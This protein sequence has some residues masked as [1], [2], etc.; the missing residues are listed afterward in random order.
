MT[1]Q[2]LLERERPESCLSDLVLDRWQASEL[3]HRPEGD[4]VRS[5]LSG[6]S[7]CAGRLRALEREPDILPASKVRSAPPV[8]SEILPSDVPPRKRSQR[9][10]AGLT[11][12]AALAAAGLVLVVTG[13]LSKSLEPTLRAKG[14]LQL[15]LVVRRT[16]GRTETVLPAD[17]LAA[18]DSVRFLVSSAEPG[19]AFVIGLDAAGAVSAY[20][21]PV[22][23]PSPLPAGR[24]QALP[25]SVILDETLGA[26]RFL[27]LYC[28]EATHIDVVLAAGRRA[29]ASA[30]GDP[31]RVERIDLPCL[32]SSMTVEKVRRP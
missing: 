1:I 12:L 3:A 2:H 21:P 29:L 23:V 16:D 27:L 14:E 31:R 30:G 9:V 20:F 25:G 26:E 7:S 10:V 32:Q 17:S 15:E 8:G 24:S 19:F 18:G 4:A 28:N 13:S 6:C 11:G 5:H 22:G